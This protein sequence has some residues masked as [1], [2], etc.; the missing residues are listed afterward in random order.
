V[1]GVLG[2]QQEEVGDAD[3]SA[4]DPGQPSEP[5]V[6][7]HPRGSRVRPREEAPGTS[8]MYADE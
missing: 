2:V 4:V 7:A 5:C 3:L 1:L 8:F 6:I